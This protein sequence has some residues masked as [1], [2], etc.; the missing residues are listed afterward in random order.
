MS[1]TLTSV[2]FFSL[3]GALT[4]VFV[5]RMTL[6]QVAVSRLLAL[7]VMI[8]SGRPYGL[9]RD[10]IVARLASGESRL[11]T[12]LADTVA[13][14]SFQLPVYLVILWFAGASLNQAIAAA[15]SALVAMLV[16]ARP[17]GLLLDL[18]RKLFGAPSRTGA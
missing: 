17:Y 18:A 1:D 7:P 12:T 9:W 2:L 13:F 6:E 11:G 10:A 15:G 8:V 3:M 14:V 16:S 5:A 4:E